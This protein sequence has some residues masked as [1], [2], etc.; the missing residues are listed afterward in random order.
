MFFAPGGVGPTPTEFQHYPTIVVSTDP[1]NENQLVATNRKGIKPSSQGKKETT[2]GRRPKSSV[3][4]KVASGATEQQ[5]SNDG[6]S[7]AN[8][9]IDDSE[10]EAYTGDSAKNN[11]ALLEAQAVARR[12]ITLTKETDGA[13]SQ[14]DEIVE[15][16][17]KMKEGV[18]V[19]ESGAIYIPSTQEPPT[20]S[21]SH[22]YGPMLLRV[23][24]S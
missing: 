1:S 12:L 14:G 2:R 8:S 5:A 19:T 4:G 16:Q 17:N 22:V 11:K 15:Q 21:C 24:T 3:K 13:L 6:S 23:L 20:K 18:V 10:G 9:T 7:D